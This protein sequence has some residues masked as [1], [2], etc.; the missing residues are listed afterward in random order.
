GGCSMGYYRAGFEVVGVDINPQKHYPFEFIKTNAL[1]VDVDFMRSFDAIHASPP[2]QG[3]SATRTQWNCGK[4]DHPKLITPVRAALEAS[5]IPWV[6]ENVM[7]STL[8]W[9]IVLCGTMFGIKTYR[10][11]VF[12]SSIMLLQPAH[13]KHPETI[14]G[15][16]FGTSPRGYCNPCGHT[17]HKGQ[18]QEWGRALDIDWMN[19][20]ELTQA[21]PPAYTEFIGRQLIE[22][23]DAIKG[24][25]LNDAH[26][27]MHV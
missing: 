4:I 19:Q 7:G 15:R 9:G 18:A 27:I 26:E 5:E 11:R 20:K 22:Y 1:S 23:L 14:P 17:S 12:E 6:I 10:H 21:I 8:H 3:Y 24:A 2:C 16:G 25:G 13:R